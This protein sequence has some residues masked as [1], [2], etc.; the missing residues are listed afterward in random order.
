MGQGQTIQRRYQDRLTLLI[1]LSI[2]SLNQHSCVTAFAPSTPILSPSI[3]QHLL[4]RTKN[5][6]VFPSK[7]SQDFSRYSQ[8][9]RQNQH[10]CTSLQ[11]S[12]NNKDNL[13]DDIPTPPTT[14]GTITESLNPLLEKIKATV[15]NIDISSAIRNTISTSP[16]SEIGSRGEIYVALQAGFVLAILFGNVPFV[17]NLFSFLLGPTLFILGLVICFLAVGELGS[18]LSPWPVPADSVDGLVKDGLVFKEVRH[19]IYTGLLCV[20]AGLSIWTGSAMRLLLTFGLYIL[21]DVKSDFEEK[22]LVAKFG[23][24]YIKYRT[25]VPGKFVPERIVKTLDRFRNGSN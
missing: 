8:C 4:I 24:E 6:H 12:Q 11:L 23:Q 14:L 1:L 2:L 19:P 13:K 9:Q 3:G 22:E 18:S 15:F 10:L 25:E 17:G 20:M 5:E 7:P 16:G 21:L